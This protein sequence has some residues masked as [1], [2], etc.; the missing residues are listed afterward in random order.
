MC[1][2]CGISPSDHHIPDQQRLHQMTQAILHRGPDSDGFH[3]D[4]GIGLGMRRLAI[5][6]VGMDHLQR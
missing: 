6:D 2:I 4:A 3:T 1:G 5:V